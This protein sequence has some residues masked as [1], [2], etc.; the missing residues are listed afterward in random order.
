MISVILHVQEN[1]SAALAR[2]LQN[3]VTFAIEGFVVEVT[4]LHGELDH[5]T[6]ILADEAGCVMRPQSEGLRPVFEATRGDWLLFMEPGST[7][8]AGWADVV[9][10]HALADGGAAQ[11]RLEVTDARAWWQRILM[12]RKFKSP[13]AKGLLISKRQARANVREQQT[14][15]M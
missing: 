15:T 13:L 12:P 9:N 7:L 6:Q 8:D 3:L 1:D 2:T 4:V 14:A 10:A 5:T 11:F